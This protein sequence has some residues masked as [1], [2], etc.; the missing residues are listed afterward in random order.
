MLTQST[1]LLRGGVP[2]CGRKRIAKTIAKS[3]AT[4]A[5]AVLVPNNTRGAWRDPPTSP[6]RSEEIGVGRAA[7]TG[8]M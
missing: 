6:M 4:V 2:V 3:A 7:R 8:G 1:L 5:M